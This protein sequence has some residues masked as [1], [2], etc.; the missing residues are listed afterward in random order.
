MAAGLSSDNNKDNG[1]DKILIYSKRKAPDSVI[2]SNVCSPV[3]SFLWMQ[4]DG[5]TK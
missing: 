1:E 3:M 4:L 5:H 2:K